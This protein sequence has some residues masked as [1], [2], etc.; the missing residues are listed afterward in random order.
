M[1]ANE[2]GAQKEKFWT[3]GGEIMFSSA[4]YIDSGQRY[5]GPPRF[6]LFLHFN[7]IYN[8][9]FG[10]R[11]GIGMGFTLKNLG[12]VTNDEPFSVPGSGEEEKTYDKIKRRSYTIGVPVMLKI[13][14]LKKSRYLV[15]GGEYD[16]LFH[17]KEKRFIS[18]Q[19]FK[20]K[21]WFS[22]ETNRF[23]PAFFVGFQVNKVGMVKVQYYLDNFLNPEF[24]ERSGNRPYANT[25]SRIVYLSW[26]GNLRTSD[27]NKNDIKPKAKPKDSY[28]AYKAMKKLKRASY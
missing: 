2:A 10:K 15:I 5:Q 26:T 18:G 9:D 17:F 27:V 24:E 28:A 6:Q 25:E 1:L 21:Q 14:D 13:G 11:V 12:F 8:V 23:V 19:K 7:A 16:M 4:D 3:S 20:R 22:S